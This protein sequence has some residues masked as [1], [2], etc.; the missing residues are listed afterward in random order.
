M[1]SQLHCTNDQY[2]FYMSIIWNNRNMIQVIGVK[3]AYLTVIFSDSQ[4]FCF[5]PYNPWLCLEVLV[6]TRH[7]ETQLE[8]NLKVPNFY[9]LSPPLQE[10]FQDWLNISYPK[11]RGEIRSLDLKISLFT[12]SRAYTNLRLHLYILLRSFNVWYFNSQKN[13]KSI[14]SEGREG[15]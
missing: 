6:P 10:I 8:T 3:V 1:A 15:R 5:C 2:M 9:T 14:K 11:V 7:E 4:T 13:I 12:C